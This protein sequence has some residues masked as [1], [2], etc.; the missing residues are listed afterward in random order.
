MVAVL[1]TLATFNETAAPMEVHVRGRPPVGQGQ[2]A[3]L[4]RGADRERASGRVTV[5]PLSISATVL[6]VRTLTATAA[7]MPTFVSP[8]LPPD[9]LL[10]EL[11]GEVIS[12]FDVGGAATPLGESDPPSL[13][14]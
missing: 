12:L 10:A 8:L 1:V 7:A 3:G 14:A 9:L 6:V 5:R 2:G 13:C 11:E 4:V